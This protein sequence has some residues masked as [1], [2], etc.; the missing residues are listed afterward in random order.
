MGSTCRKAVSRQTRCL[1]QGADRWVIGGGV[2]NVRWW[3]GSEARAL[4]LA[5]RM[6]VREFAAHLGV[7][8]A[9]VSNW[10]RHREG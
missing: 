9:A 8:D 1:R 3:T 10:E 2:A 6:S 4:R 5:I 7:N